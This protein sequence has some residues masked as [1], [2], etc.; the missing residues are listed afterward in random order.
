MRLLQAFRRNNPDHQIDFTEEV[1]VDY[2]YTRE[3]I[4]S[5]R[6]RRWQCYLAVDGHRV[7]IL[8]TLSELR[9]VDPRSNSGQAIYEGLVA[10]AN[11]YLSE[12]GIEL[13]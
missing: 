4:R 12:H 10:H 1:L 9:R 7:S 3:N 8:Y 13:V 5:E 11:R 6:G 2:G